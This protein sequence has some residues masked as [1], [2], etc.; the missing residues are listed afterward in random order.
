MKNKMEYLS[1]EQ[2]KFMKHHTGKITKP[3]GK[4]KVNELFFITLPYCYAQ[5][6]LS[7]GSKLSNLQ[8]KKLLK[9]WVYF[10]SQSFT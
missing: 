9:I 5:S 1:S 6:A 8:Q 3:I 7:E 10:C 4:H 2:I